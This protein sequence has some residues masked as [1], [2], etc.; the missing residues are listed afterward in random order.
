MGIGIAI[1]YTY[2]YYDMTNLLSVVPDDYL[3]KG[4]SR[5]C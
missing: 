1:K 2:V 3:V 4:N 5:L